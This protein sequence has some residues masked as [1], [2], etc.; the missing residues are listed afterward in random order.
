[1]VQRRRATPRLMK[2]PAVGFFGFVLFGFLLGGFVLLGFAVVDGV[3]DTVVV[4]GDGT[5]LSTVL[6]DFDRLVR[7]VIGFVIGIVVGFA[8]TFAFG[9]VVG[10]DVLVGFVVGFPFVVSSVLVVVSGIVV[11]GVLAIDVLA[12]DVIGVASA[13]GFSLSAAA[14][15]IRSTGFFARRR[16]T[17]RQRTAPKSRSTQPGR[18]A[19]KSRPIQ[20]GRTTPQPG[21]TTPQPGRTAPKSR[22]VQPG[23]DEVPKRVFISY[24][25]EDE[26]YKTWVKRLAARLRNDGID[27]RLDAWHRENRTFSA[28]MTSEIRLADW[29]L[30]LC[31]PQY[32]EKVHHTEAGKEQTGV[33]WESGLI[34]SKMAANHDVRVVVALGRGKRD[35]AVPDFLVGRLCYT[36]GDPETFEKQYLE[37]LR[38]ITGKTEQAPPLGSLPDDLDPV[39]VEPL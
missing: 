32:R 18:T 11:S 33:G 24:A 23:R 31:S 1:M 38:E 25:W 13:L 26:G 7:V 10:E 29:V 5:L 20:P 22:P 35:D 27:A 14:A 4:D 3:V 16:T 12:I 39:S 9:F 30:V 21:R 28:F 36:L 15:S 17:E 8:F 19:P 2:K 37:V 6:G 34:S